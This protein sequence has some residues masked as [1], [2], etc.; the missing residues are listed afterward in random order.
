[1]ILSVQNKIIKQICKLKTKKEREKI[2]LAIIEGERFINQIPENIEIE[3]YAFS[4]SFSN[5]INVFEVYKNKP[6]YIIKDD[7][8]KKISE[9]IT[10]QGAMAICK[11]KQNYFNDLKINK[12]SIFLILDRVM[13]PGNLGTIIRSAEAFGVS[14]IFLSKGCVDLYNDKVLRSTMGSLFNI[15]IIDNC[16]IPEIINNL[17]E[18]EFNIVCTHL[19]GE[20]KPFEVNFL[21]KTA[22]IIGNEAN[23]VLDEY[24]NISD[25]IVKIHMVGKV[26][27]INVSIAT[28]IILYEALSQRLKYN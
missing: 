12:N 25:E 18:K 17:K 16:N 21:N 11:I 5:K 28:S 2:G 22:I 3:Y 10:P 4:E 13:D 7:I 8:F 27:S 26:E 24:V 9:T 6:I 14:A 19:K 15:P 1:M 23:G 20:K